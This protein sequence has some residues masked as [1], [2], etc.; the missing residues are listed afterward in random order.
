MNRIGFLLVLIPFVG[1]CGGARYYTFSSYNDWS[2]G[3]MTDVRIWSQGGISPAAPLDSVEISDEDYIWCMDTGPSGEVFLGTGARGRLYM[4]SNGEASLF[5]DSPESDILSVTVK[6]KD[7]LWIGCSPDGLIYRINRKTREVEEYVTDQSSVWSLVPY[8]NGVLAATGPYGKVFYC[9]PS[10]EVREF[11]SLP[12]INVMSLLAISDDEI[13]AVTES[14]ALVVRLREDCGYFTV[15]R[16]DYMELRGLVSIP[17]DSI[18]FIGLTPTMPLPDHQA[19]V[20]WGAASGPFEACWSSPDSILMDLVSNNGTLLAVGGWPGRLYG[21][22]DDRTFRRI[23]E[24]NRPQIICASVG[25]RKTI[26]LGAGN[27]ACL[28]TLNVAGDETGEWQSPILDADLAADW[29]RVEIIASES[30]DLKIQARSGNLGS[31]GDGWS[32]WIE[33]SEQFDGWNVDVPKA[34]YAQFKLDI[35]DESRIGYPSVEWLQI[36]YK[37]DNRQPR[38]TDIELMDKGETPPGVYRAPTRSM[39]P[40]VATDPSKAGKSEDSIRSEDGGKNDR[41]LTWKAVDPDN[42]GLLY[43]IACKSNAGRSWIMLAEKTEDD[44]LRIE[45]GSLADGWYTFKV[46]ASDEPGN[47]S[48]KARST[49]RTLGP[50]IIDESPPL[51]EK[52]SWND[53][54]NGKTAIMEVFDPGSGLS[55]AA[56][57]IDGGRWTNLE[58]DDGIT[59]EQYESFALSGIHS[60]TS[61]TVRLTD[62]AGNIASVSI[63]R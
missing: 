58:A 61:M 43:S 52:V 62:R 12:V 25:P 34:R 37:A 17:G 36:S 16:M 38:I 48:G 3:S 33:L 2:S 40:R 6:G 44:Y 56:V 15:G 49:T 42:D 30:C 20:L 60:F 45:Y 27:P 31:P 5:F 55:S 32:Q 47:P 14:P 13:Y 28:Y 57:S 35:R 53:G 10:H 22:E 63:T 29:G 11:A 51:L 54:D 9:E 39:L 19:A 41:Y 21:I 46:T 59:D 50:V 18:A 4:I 1:Y 24:A 7:D 8:R 26:H 23:A